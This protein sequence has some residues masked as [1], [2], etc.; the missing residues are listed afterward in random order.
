MAMSHTDALPL[1][2]WKPIDIRVFLPRFLQRFHLGRYMISQHQDVEEKLM[3][4]LHALQ[5]SDAE[6]ES[7]ARG[8]GYEDLRRLPYLQAVIKVR[9]I[10]LT[11]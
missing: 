8:I 9:E 5:D 10:M 1:C 11:C 2:I 4:E 7:G 6:L 3:D